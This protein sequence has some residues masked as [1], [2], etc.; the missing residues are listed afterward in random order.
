MAVY[1]QK[2][3]KY[4]GY[5]RLTLPKAL[6][7]DVGLDKADVLQITKLTRFTLAVR[8]Y[9]GKKTRKRSI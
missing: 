3:T 1:I 2:L 9:H 6:V 8:E 4:R 7:E 5:Y